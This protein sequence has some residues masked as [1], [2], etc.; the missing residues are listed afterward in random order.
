MMRKWIAFCLCLVMLVAMTACKDSG[1]NHNDES[2][3]SVAT[4]YVLDDAL[5]SFIT[6]FNTQT[7]YTLAG[8]VQ[9]SDGSVS[10]EI[11]MCTIHMKSTKYGVYISLMGGDTVESRDRM[12]DIFSTIT[13]AVDK[14]CPQS[15]LA[16]VV[17]KYKKQTESSSNE[18][19]VSNYMKVLTFVP[20]INEGTVKVDCRMELL[21]LKYTPTDK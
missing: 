17:D 15:Q 12:L 1:D 20:V 14:S 4:R 16:V 13:L 8:M 5:N 19:R 21:V 6:D 2:D 7:R 3:E 9:E 18:F 11:D 10:A